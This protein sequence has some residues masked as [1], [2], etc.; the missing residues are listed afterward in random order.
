[1]KGR[2]AFLLGHHDNSPVYSS[3]IAERK[4]LNIT[5]RDVK[6][7]TCNPKVFIL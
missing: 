7:T 6:K 2:A 1:M 3:R 4:V 5:L